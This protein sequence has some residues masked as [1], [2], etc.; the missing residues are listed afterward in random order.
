M[1]VLWNPAGDKYAIMFDK[2]IN[3]YN[4]AVSIEVTHFYTNLVLNNAVDLI[5][6]QNSDNHFT[7]IKISHYAIF[8]F[9]KD[10]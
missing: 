4:V 10:R 7:H 1:V 2:T 3:I 6:R 9:Y 8:P 5:G